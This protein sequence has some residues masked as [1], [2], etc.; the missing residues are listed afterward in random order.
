[1]RSCFFYSLLSASLFLTGYAIEMI[2]PDFESSMLRETI[3][4]SEKIMKKKKLYL[5]RNPVYVNLFHEFYDKAV[6]EAVQSEVTHARIPKIIHQICLDSRVSLKFRDSIESWMRL[7]GWEYRL[8]T[9]EKIKQLKMYN[10]DLYESC[11][12]PIEKSDMARL[13]ILSKFGGVFVDMNYECVNPQIFEELHQKFDFYI[14]FNPVE[15]GKINMFQVSN[16]IIGSVPFHPLVQDLIINL[17]SSYLAY[18]NYSPAE[19]TGS[20]YYTRVI[21]QYAA[22]EKTLQGPPIF[23][24]IYLPATFFYFLTELDDVEQLSLF[25]EENFPAE[26]ASVHHFKVKSVKKRD[27]EVAVRVGKENDD[28]DKNM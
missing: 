18:K 9:E 8:W 21:C 23:R 28:K 24:N 13:E 14:G 10:Q 12:N 17:K 1:M 27:G 4:S 5:E 19:K 11:K 3:D 20:A 6:L 22:V 15:H 2:Y 7:E 16:A 26:I 25:M